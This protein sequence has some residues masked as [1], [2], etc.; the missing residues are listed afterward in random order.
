M[1]KNEDNT[2][3][4]PGGAIPLRTQADTHSAGIRS[5]GSMIMDRLGLA[6]RLGLQFGGKRDLYKVY[7]YSRIISFEEYYGRYTRQDIA[8]RI[9]NAAPDATWK[10]PPELQASDKFKDAW[11]KIITDHDVW[12]VLTR[13]DR[14]AGIGNYSVVLLGFSDSGKLELPVKKKEGLELLYMQPYMQCD[15][16]IVELE[17]DVT[18]ARF[19]EPRMYEIKLTD[20]MQTA[21]TTAGTA[22]KKS[23]QDKTMKVHY[24]RILH[25]A[26]D[27]KSNNFIGTPRLEAVYNLLDDLLKVSGG[28]AE[29]Y[30]LTSNRGMQI[31]IDKDAEMSV[32]DAKNLS[33]EV[34]EFT[35]D[36]RRI[37]R[38]R[39]VEMK[40]LGA[41]T[42]DPKNTFN[43]IIALM[44]AAT[45]IP[46]RIMLGAEAGQLASDQDRA[47]WADRI[48][49]RRNTFAEPNV[50]KPFIDILQNAGI[51]PEEDDAKRDFQWPATFE[52]TPLETAQ[53]M[54][55]RAR[56]II[57]VSKHFLEHPLISEE[58]A[59][60]LTGFPEKCTMGTIPK[61]PESSSGSAKGRVPGKAG[62]EDNTEDGDRQE[63]IAEA[64][65]G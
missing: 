60:I 49:E 59:R 12:G 65:N 37:V 11:K 24:S 57:N 62:N 17:D 13:A 16:T 44:A 3:H 34:D 52:M 38:T 22:V 48:K 21:Y 50:L 5:L 25:I 8:K 4:R 58:E 61:A 33:D 32:D 28:T 31:N 18:N 10:N 35:N 19:G 56:A 20:A 64:N 42:P 54:A 14:M 53:M 55:Q 30:W 15:A 27:L 43:M 39:G 46:Q 45:G 6:S 2:E 63:N 41:N 47:N 36:L 29:T 26:E 9:V 40:N 7:G 51:L 23:V 1:S